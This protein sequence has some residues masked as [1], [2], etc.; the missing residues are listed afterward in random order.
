MTE[1]EVPIDTSEQ[2]CLDIGGTFENGVCEI[3]DEE[4]PTILSLANNLCIITPTGENDQ[5][6]PP[7]LLDGELDVNTLYLIGGGLAVVGIIVLALKR[8]N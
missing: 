1:C 6:P 7:T 2:Q 3:D 5:P 8:R 4:C